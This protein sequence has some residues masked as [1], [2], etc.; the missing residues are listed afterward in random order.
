MAKR[1]S[2]SDAL[3][4]LGQDDSAVV[5]F[6]EKLSEGA[7]GVVGIPGLSSLGG[8]VAQA[9]RRAITG[10]R[11]KVT[12]ISRM[13]RTER[14]M[15]ARKILVAVAAFEALDE[16]LQDSPVELALADLEMDA[17]EQLALSKGF[18]LEDAGHLSLLVDADFSPGIRVG[19]QSGFFAYRLADFLRGLAV[20]ERLDQT[21]RSSAAEAIQERL[22]DLAARRF[23]ESYRL[24]A[25]EV[26]EFGVW[27]NLSAHGATQQRVAEIDTGLARLHALVTEMAPRHQLDRRRSELAALYQAALRRPL[28]RSADAPPGLQLPTLESAY[29]APR[30]R[31]ELAVPG[32]AP[33]AETWWE[34]VPTRD[35]LQSLLAGLL[36]TPNAVDRPI[37]VLGHPGAGKSVLTEMLAARLSTADFFALRVELRA[38]S[39]NAPIHKQ[40]EESV[41][42]TLN[43]AVQWR[44]LAESAGGALPVVILD[45]FDELLQAS[46][47]N[48]SDYLEQVQEFQHQQEALGQ[49]VAVIVTSRTVVAERA[50]FPVET[51]VLRLEPLSE[52]QIARMV[53]LWNASNGTAYSSRGL[54]AP[55]A[56]ALLPF[57]ELA[58]QP[59]LL[60]MLLVY[61][62]ADN[63]LQRSGGELSRSGLY[64]ELLSGFAEREVRKHRS[65]LSDAELANAIEDELH[66]LEV[67]AVAMFVRQRQS[68]AADELKQDLAVLMPDSGTRPAEAGLHGTVSD[69][70]QVLGRFFFVHESQARIE[71]RTASVFEFLHAT[72]GEYL[73]ARAVTAELAELLEARR[74][75]ARRPRA[76]PP[77]DDGLLYALTSFSL[78]AGSAATVEFTGDLL[79]RRIAGKHGERAEYR[80]LLIDLFREAPY[81]AENRAYTA[82]Q[83]R[84]LPITD[85]QAAYTANLATMLTRVAP[86]GVDIAELFDNEHGWQNVSDWRALAGQWRGLPNTQWHGFL[87]V[88]RLRHIG[89]G[90]DAQP[91]TVLSADTQTSVGECVGFEIT[92]GTRAALSVLDPY[93]IAL[94][95][96]VT[97]GLLRSTAMRINGTAARMTLMMLPLLEHVGGNLLDWFEDTDEGTAWSRM[98]DLLEL[99]LALPDPE[100]DRLSRR[101]RRY[102]RLLDTDVLGTV[103]ALVLRQVA[104]DLSHTAQAGSTQGEMYARELLDVAAYYLGAVRSV[105]AAASASADAL[106][107]VFDELGRH[108]NHPGVPAGTYSRIMDAARAGQTEGDGQVSPPG[109]TDHPHPPSDGVPH[110]P[111]RETFP[112]AQRR[113]ARSSAALAPYSHEHGDRSFWGSG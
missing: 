61:D 5:G 20:W 24:L 82:Y 41:G 30:G 16:V 29:L 105:S 72:F 47:V 65:H 109:S 97:G 49:P 18:L 102:E 112:Q 35:D 113:R 32:A 73:V 78:L 104:E 80:E 64:E 33:S 56:E 50:R 3:K 17:E 75:A 103:E 53:D 38:V 42:A 21:T 93:S 4:M 55:T 66:R 62:A 67:A 39:P 84:R 25:A 43:T 14:V 100:S 91:R 108:G 27:A 6:A 101:M 90:G 23:T 9:G 83:P 44:A 96:G 81:P 107:V 15:A 106:T 34:N 22:P 59:L 87:E 57:R 68:V 40:I 99:R 69:A 48:R 11:E 51:P 71:S 111:P 10:L 63:A 31:Y 19:T 98:H 36:T 94:P 7:L 45:G 85:R 13:D 92:S 2:Y 28:L 76:A 74:F 60:L 12:G 54:Q 46:G 79:D 26:P 52:R 8:P 86:E 110:P 1:L 77:T 89:Y 37:V 95:S 88:V 70:H 58:E